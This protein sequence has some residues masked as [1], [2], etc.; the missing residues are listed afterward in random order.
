[1]LSVVLGARSD[2]G[3]ASESQKLLNYGFQAYDT[4]QL[5]PSELPVSTLRVWKGA[6]D[7]LPVGFFTAQYLTLPKGK[8][9]KLALTMAAT[10]PLVAPVTK[11]QHVGSVK[12]ALDGKPVAEY[13]L[14]A[15]Q[16]VPTGS[17][18]GRAW[19]TVRLWVKQP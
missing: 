4:I 16:D 10:E 5:Y 3:R 12:V 8:A 6:A 17:F 11:G 13:P 9:D 7:E 2:A 18:F 15:L 19:D 14:L 1:V